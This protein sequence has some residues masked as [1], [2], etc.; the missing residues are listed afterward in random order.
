MR[1]IL[2]SFFYTG[3]A[4]YVSGTAGS[5]LAAGFY[6]AL[7]YLGIHSSVFFLAI[8]IAAFCLTVLLG[9]WAV[10]FYGNND[11][12]Q[13]VL[14][15]VA[16]YFISAALFIPVEPLKAAFAAF[17]LFRVFD[18]LKPPPCRILEKLPAG[19]G[20][21]LDD[22]VAGIYTNILLHALLLACGRFGIQ[23]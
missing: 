1:R 3:Y 10:K 17:F 2:V 9:Y 20:I 18:V 5:A 16:G 11:P 22:L 15:E 12:R 7:R 6:L 19:Y 21:A 14:D 8:G 4:P 23:I 13:V